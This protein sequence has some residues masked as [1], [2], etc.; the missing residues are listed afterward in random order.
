MRLARVCFILAQS[1]E[2]GG[3]SMGSAPAAS[4]VCGDSA[5]WRAGSAALL[6]L[7]A[8]GVIRRV[9]RG[10]EGQGVS[11]WRW[12]ADK[13]RRQAPAN[14]VLTFWGDQQAAACAGLN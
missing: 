1:A 9:K 6:D 2:T 8:A 12:T 14:S 4:V 7:Q 5:N 10:R 11:V 13:P 3:F